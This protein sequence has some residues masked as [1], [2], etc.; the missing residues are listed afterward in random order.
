M[1]SAPARWELWKAIHAH[2]RSAPRA[3][4][5][6][7]LD[8]FCRATGYHRKYA[9]RLLNG[10]P[11]GAARPRRR[12][13]PATYSGAMIQAL[14]VIWE[15]AGYPWSVRLKALRPAWLPWAR[16]RLGLSAAVCRQLRA[17]SARQIDRR[18]AP[19]KR[20]LRA[21]RYGRT[22][23]GSLLK[24]HIPLKTDHWAVT[25]PGFAEVDLVAHAGSRADGEFAHSLNVTDIHTTWVETRA[26]LGRGEV[27]VHEAW[28]TSARPSRFACRAS[29][30][31]MAR[32][33][34]TT[35][36]IATAR[37]RRSNSRGG[38][39]TRKT[40][41]L[42]LSRRTGPMSASSWATTATTRRARSRRSTTSTVTSS[43]SSK[44]CSC[45]RSSSSARSA[46]GRASAAATM[47]RAHPS[48][49]SRPAHRSSARRGPTRRPARSPRSLRPG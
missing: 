11:A 25:V 44:I 12:R 27:G 13:R 35:T 4:K 43:V 6:R 30:P 15:A 1:M 33:S 28:R 38:G 29:T 36:C 16:R 18:L 32:S 2:Y 49:A 46:S 23:P 3:S 37:R 20:Q 39:P 48:S 47:P 26:V 24:H 22:K 34:S 31:T 42:T 45:P 5:G 7:I 21:R 19:L 40:T 17:I 10:A 41:T 8:E 9:L 14:R